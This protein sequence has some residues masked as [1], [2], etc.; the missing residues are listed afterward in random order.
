MIACKYICVYMCVCMWGA[1]SHIAERFNRIDADFLL[2]FSCIVL[3]TNICKYV[4][5]CVGVSVSLLGCL[6]FSALLL[7]ILHFLAKNLHLPTSKKNNAFD[8]LALFNCTWISLQKVCALYCFFHNFL[9][10]SYIV[11]AFCIKIVVLE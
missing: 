4:C 6:S 2:N 10:T 8:S 3:T 1:W 11:D 5:L 7:F 9:L